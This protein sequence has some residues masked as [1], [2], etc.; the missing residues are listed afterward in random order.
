MQ[1][2]F[3]SQLAQ[4]SV[5]EAEARLIFRF[6]EERGIAVEDRHRRTIE[7]CRDIETLELWIMRAATVES[8]D[9][10]F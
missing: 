2:E 8:A 1:Y 9:D 4:Q 6:L 5:A 10:L 3:G 7:Q